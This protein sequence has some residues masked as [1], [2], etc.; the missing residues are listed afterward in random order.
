LDTLK[1]RVE[2]RPVRT[3]SG[4]KR[5]AVRQELL[6][7]PK[8]NI[9]LNSI[10]RGS[11]NTWKSYLTSFVHF[12]QFLNKKYQGQNYNPDSI[13]EKILSNQIDLY[14]LLESFISSLTGAPKSIRVYADAVRSFLEYYDVEISQKKFKK[15]CRLPKLY[16]EDEEALTAG[17]IRKLLL[18]CSN[19]RLRPY[20]LTLASGG[21]RALE[22][23]AIRNRDINFDVRPVTVKIRKEYSKTK[24]A[25]YFFISDEAAHAIKQWIDWKYRNKADKRVQKYYHD[26]DLVFTTQKFRDCVPNSVYFKIRN[27]FN[28]LQEIVGTSERKDGSIRRKYTL[29]SF[30]RFV[31]TVLETNIS[32]SYSEWALGHAKS[33][34]WVKTPEE[35]AEEYLKVMK[36]LT[37]LDYTTLEATGKNIEARIS[38]KDT[39]IQLLRQ[40]DQ[41]KDEALSQ[42]S[43]KLQE[44]M[45]KVQLLEKR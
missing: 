20:L 16:R 18:S 24:V 6:L 41:M 22:A 36:Y 38:E 28:T 33:S 31:K 44:V 37:F 39:E 11:V 4:W 29:H 17:I 1:D 14:E 35:K 5:S 21:F 45:E 27:E 2:E 26:D 19:R 23:L 32:S 12:Q 30:R 40:R 34:Y 10:K 7:K 43:D 15:R 25:R 8:L 13:L 3:S 9:F 42:L